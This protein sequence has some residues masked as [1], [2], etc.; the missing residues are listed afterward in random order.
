M[1]RRLEGGERVGHVGGW[2]NSGTGRVNGKCKGPGAPAWS[3][4]EQGQRRHRRVSRGGA[5]DR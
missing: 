1:E 3:E 2:G 4:G 5:G